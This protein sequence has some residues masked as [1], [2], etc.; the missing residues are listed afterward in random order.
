MKLKKILQSFLLLPNEAFRKRSNILVTKS[1]IRMRWNGPLNYN[2][3]DDI[4]YHLIKLLSNK[5]IVDYKSSIIS[6]ILKTQHYL[7]IGSILEMHSDKDARVWGTGAMS[8]NRKITPPKAVYAVRGPLTRKRLLDI[9]VECPEVYGDPALLTSIVVP[10]DRHIRYKLGIIPHVEDRSNPIIQDLCRRYP[11]DVLII[12]MG[13]YGDWKNIPKQICQCECIISSSLHGL[14]VADSYS[15]P[16]LWIELS[17]KVGGNGFK[18]R[19]YMFSV[20][21]DKNIVPIIRKESF[22]LNDVDKYMLE[23]QKPQIDL[24]LLIDS[25]PFISEDKKYSLKVAIK[26]RKLMI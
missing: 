3:G 17:D 9:G 16:N 14:I 12:D 26:E 24:G 25:C 4:N 10:V 19:D 20:K 22:D 1:F 6:K 18:F 13:Q 23:Y 8:K 21:R 11:N 15:V 5:E 7:V 2:W